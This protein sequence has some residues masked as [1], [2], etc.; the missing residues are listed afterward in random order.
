MVRHYIGIDPGKNGGIA[1]LDEEGPIE[2]TVMPDTVAGVYDWLSSLATSLTN[3]AM[4][5]EMAQPMPKQG[6]VSVF[7]YGRH[8]G[9]FEV[10]ARAFGIPYHE[11]RPAVWKKAMGLSSDKVDSIQLCQRLFPSANLTPDRCRKPHDGMAEAILVAEWG[12][13]QR[14]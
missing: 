4:V 5:I 11:V 8:F 1:L 14:L 2:Y 6:V 3:A 12:R 9:A 7:T 13:R 10:L